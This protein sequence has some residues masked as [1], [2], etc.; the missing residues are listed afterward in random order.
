MLDLQNSLNQV[1]KVVH[2]CFDDQIQQ[3]LAKM[4]VPV[5]S[6]LSKYFELER[7]Q[8]SV[9]FKSKKKNN[10]INLAILSHY[11]EDEVIQ[12]YLREALLNLPEVAEFS[13]VKFIARR[14]AHL[15]LYL[16]NVILERGTRYLFGNK[17]NIRELKQSLLTFYFYFTTDTGSPKPKRLIGVGYRDKG[18]LPDNVEWLPRH[19]ITLTSEQMKIESNRKTA[20]DLEDLITGLLI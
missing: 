20:R 13:L 15:E 5:T 9:K 1:D 17:L 18:H 12:F 19:D 11:I 10:L 3:H 8:I 14:K 4:T 7:K 16:E 2:Q 6:T